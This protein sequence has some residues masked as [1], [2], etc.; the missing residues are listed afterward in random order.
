M[1]YLSII[2]LCAISC[3]PFSAATPDS[4]LTISWE[5][6]MLKVKGPFPG[7]VMDTWY[8]E[9][10]CRSGS[11]HQAWDKTTIPHKT[12]LVSADK[13]GKH[14]RLRTQVEPSVVVEHEITAGKDDVT[15]KLKA[16]NTG[17]DFVDVQWFQPCTRVN[18]FTERKQDD[19][20]QRCFILTKEG[21][22]MMDQLPR[23]EEAIYKGGQVYVPEGVPMN[24]VNP[25]PIS[26]VTP[27]NALIGCV[28][29]D[30][31]WLFATAWDQTQE[32]FQGVIVCI[33]N[34]P[35]IGGL[36][37]GETRELRGKMYFLPNDPAKL[38][39]RYQHDFP[40]HTKK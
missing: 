22:K 21:L 7:E 31:K 14:L 1:R 35:R 3:L 29:P 27:A 28:S 36:K 15:F 9:A 18:R 2:A 17:K 38:L 5:K 23:A 6:G 24:D 10:F 11:T 4:G 19:Y 16:T 8:L 26:S 37:P 34:D 30:N 12:E 39:K 40:T 32:L 20:H 13:E 33:H 25:R